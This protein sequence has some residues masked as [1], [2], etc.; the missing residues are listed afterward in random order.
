MVIDGGYG[1]N[2]PSTILDCTADEVELIRE[3]LGNLD[4]Y[5]V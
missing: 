2:I 4:D 1:N 3:G 5:G